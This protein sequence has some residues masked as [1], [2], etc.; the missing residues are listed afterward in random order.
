MYMISMWT[1]FLA[2]YPKKTLPVWTIHPRIRSTST[3][4]TGAVAKCADYCVRAVARCSISTQGYVLPLRRARVL[5]KCMELLYKD[6]NANDGETSWTAEHLGELDLEHDSAFVVFRSHHTVAVHLWLSLFA[7]RSAW[8][9]MTSTVS[10]H[11]EEACNI[12]LHGLI[13][14]SSIETDPKMTRSPTH[15]KKLTRQEHGI[16]SLHVRVKNVSNVIQSTPPKETGA[17]KVVFVFDL[18]I[19]NFVSLVK[20]IY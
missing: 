6:R 10:Y 2:I 16:F 4:M 5:L 1:A 19:I 13:P 3:D 17:Q 20:T 12:I 18:E 8:L 15:A 9:L 11:V 7:Y 14:N